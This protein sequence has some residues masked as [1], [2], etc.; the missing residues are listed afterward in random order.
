MAHLAQLNVARLAHDLEHPDLQPFVTALDAVNADA[1]AAP[2]FVWR[3]DE[4]EPSMARIRLFGRDMIVNLSVWT[5]LDVLEAYVYGDA[6]LAVL[7]QRRSFFTRMSTPNLVL[8]WVPEGHVPS[9]AEA[10]ERLD[11]LGAEGPAPS[12]FTM[13]QAFDAEGRPLH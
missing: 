4:D 5:D 7:R 12:A 13:R 8:W 2:G 1:D 11:R 9:L 3:W 10:R 6:H